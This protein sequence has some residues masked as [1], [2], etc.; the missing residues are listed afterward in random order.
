MAIFQFHLINHSIELFE[1]DQN[2][3]IFMQKIGRKKGNEKEGNKIEIFTSLCAFTG[4]CD[5][6]SVFNDPLANTSIS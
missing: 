6:E 2:E 4:A 3:I 5:S 1:M